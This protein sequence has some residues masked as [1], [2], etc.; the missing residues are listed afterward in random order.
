MIGSET[1]TKV[2]T[3]FWIF[4]FACLYFLKL[5]QKN[6][7]HFPGYYEEGA[8]TRPGSGV[9]ESAKA[10]EWGRTLVPLVVSTQVL[11]HPSSSPKAA[12]SKAHHRPLLVATGSIFSEVDQAP[13]FQKHWDNRF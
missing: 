6:A 1:L 7:C 9:W 12:A 11:S 2:I 10:A 13:D 4:C 3:R 8:H 5:L